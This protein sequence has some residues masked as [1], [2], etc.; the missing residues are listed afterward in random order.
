MYKNQYTDI[1]YSDATLSPYII[2]AYEF[3]IMR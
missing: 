2:E 3:G 1:D